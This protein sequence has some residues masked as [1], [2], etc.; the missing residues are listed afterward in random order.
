MGTYTKDLKKT[1]EAQKDTAG[2]AGL[3]FLY[4]R[5]DWTTHEAV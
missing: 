4:G 1:Y 3:D 5:S 2:Q